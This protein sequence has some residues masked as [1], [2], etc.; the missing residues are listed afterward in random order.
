[1]IALYAARR[2]KTELIDYHLPEAL[3]AQ[4]PH[5]ERD[6]GRLLALRRGGLEHRR[7]TELAELVPEGALI[8]VNDSRVLRARLL[9]RR[10]GSGGRAEIFLLRRLSPPGPRERWSAIGRASKTLRAGSVI[11]CGALAARVVA[12]EAS[13]ELAV[14]LESELPIAEAIE[15]AGH[16]PLPPYVR[17]DDTAEDGTR[18]QTVYAASPG[19]VAAPTAGL[20]LSEALLARLAARGV[21]IGRV[22]LHVGIG[23][24]RPVTADDLDAHPMHAEECV[25]STELAAQIGRARERH[26]PVV[27]I[28][29]TVVRALESA[30]DPERSGFVQPFSGET[31]LLIQPGHAFRVVDA[32]FTNFHMP[33][34][35]LLALVCAFAGRERTLA[36]Y[37]EAVATDYR[38]LSYGDAMWIEERMR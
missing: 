36:A 29:T 22:T 33:R 37:R 18:Y 24:F 10:R 8:V 26:G 20:H 34:S 12:R 31:R 9:G 6:G 5:P 23:T 11:D 2:L 17:R 25:V 7:I 3:I 14:E 38:F 32:L 15:R 30:A 27:A 13:G 4:H 21:E 16:V 35:T 28:G 1:M 19:S